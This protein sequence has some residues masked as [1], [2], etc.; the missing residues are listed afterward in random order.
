MPTYEYQCEKCDEL[1]EYFQQITEAPKA[2]CEKCGG[3]LTKLLSG[4]SG[5]I[6]KG[7]GFYITDYKKGGDSGAKGETKGGGVSDP[8][9]GAKSESSDSAAKPEP[10]KAGD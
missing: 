10:A 8:K 6:F 7:T 2:V 3:K 9:K 5:L 1:F 4:G